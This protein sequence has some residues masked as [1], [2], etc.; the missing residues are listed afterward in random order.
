MKLSDGEKLIIVMLA[1]IHKALKI[2]NAEVDP[3]FVLDIV[4]SPHKWAL[5]WKY[6][7]IFNDDEEDDRLAVTETCDVLDMWTAL[8]ASYKHLSPADKKRVET[9][10]APF[11][12]KVKFPGF[13]GNNEPHHGIASTLIEKLGRW[14]NFDGRNLNSHSPTI[15]SARRMLS[16][17]KPLMGTGA[18]LHQLDADQVIAILKEQTHPSMRTP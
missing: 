16:V 7:G 14:S 1:D 18:T 8:E 13:D 6:S 17:F 12:K 4:T 10:A 5:R 9:E 11:G 3:Q 2:K 15:D